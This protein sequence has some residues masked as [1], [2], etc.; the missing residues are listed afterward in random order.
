[1]SNAIAAIFRKMAERLEK[2]EGEPFG[3]AAVIIPPGEFNEAIAVQ[4]LSLDP[5]PDGALFWG[6]IRSKADE[7]VADLAQRARQQ[8]AFRR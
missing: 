7:A 3:G 2:N 8:N 4:M 5:A 6:Q 1:M